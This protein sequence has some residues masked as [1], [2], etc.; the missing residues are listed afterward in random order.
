MTTLLR[1]LAP[2]LALLYLLL[3]GCT[4]VP[5]GQP[6]DTAA[7]A[8]AEALFRSGDHAAA[9]AA[10]GELAATASGERRQ[11]LRLRQA[12]ALARA[13]ELD[14]ARRLLQQVEAEALAPPGLPLRLARAHL[15]LAARMPDAALEALAAP[16]PA[17]A[18]PELQAEFHLLRS[19][20][21]ALQGNHLEAARERILRESFLDDPGAQLENQKAIWSELGSLTERAL[22]RLRVAPPPDVLSGWMELVRLAKRFQLRPE[23]LRKALAEWRR[24]YP[25]H[26]ARDELLQG[27]LERKAEDVTYPER[28]ALLVPLSGRFAR[29]GEA[30]RDGFLAAYY[31]HRPEAM[32]ELRIYDTGG[33]PARIDVIYA[34]AVTD[35]ARFVVGPLDKAAAERLAS[36]GDL[37]VPTLALNY[38]PLDT[39]PANLYQFGLS[40][41]DEARQVAERTWLDG[42]VNGVA[43]IPAG[44]WGERVFRAFDARWTELG[45]RTLEVQAYN[46]GDNDFSVPIRRLL[47]I[48][49]SR[50][51]YRR[52]RTLL[53]ERLKFSPRRRQDIDFIFVAAYPRQ[54][55]QIRPQ[56]KFYHATDLPVYATSHVYTG[57]LNREKDRDM[58]GIVFGDMPWVLSETYSHSSLRGEIE[59]HITPAGRGLQRLY[60]LGIDAFNIIAALNPLRRYPYER[61]DGETGS[62]SLD[63]KNRVHRQLTWVRF[64]SGQPT[65]LDTEVQ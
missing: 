3:A 38:V 25:S 53:K 45:G 27:L 32:H 48:N 42:H 50:R 14:A 44:P 12:A 4:T 20:A 64:R 1:R 22:Q 9:A 40:P 10:L 60:A 26:P 62:L 2:A 39:P 15:A 46:P 34:Q 17:D 65:L 36:R 51:R 24:D 49:D 63:E 31:T 37:P 43:L 59:P 41:E 55:R 6:P 61:Y 47:N 33:D 57:S 54:A 35:G 16:P 5:E 56:L 30:V 21:F 28:L 11:Y 58:D 23:Q 18:P 7:L 13:G 29:A 8:R 19:E 52:L